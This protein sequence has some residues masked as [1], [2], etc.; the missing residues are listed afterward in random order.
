MAKVDRKTLDKIFNEVNEE[1][2]E[3]LSEFDHWQDYY[4]H[5][6]EDWCNSLYDYDDMGDF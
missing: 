5:F 2:K 3:D 1:I 6:D 4:H